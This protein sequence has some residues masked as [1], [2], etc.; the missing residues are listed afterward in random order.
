M[1]L[2]FKDIIRA[3]RQS[4]FVLLLMLATALRKEDSKPLIE[5]SDLA[6]SIFRTLR[7]LF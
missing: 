2:Y 6:S 3:Y 5:I 4:L 7:V 1:V